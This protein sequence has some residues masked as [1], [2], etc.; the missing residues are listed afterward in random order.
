MFENGKKIPNN[1]NNYPQQIPNQEEEWI[2]VF[3]ISAMNNFV[4]P[5]IF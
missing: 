2:C 1:Q 5:S 4:I 3:Y